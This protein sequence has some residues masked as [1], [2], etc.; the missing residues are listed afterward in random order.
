LQF[1]DRF[2]EIELMF[3][4]LG[5]LVVLCAPIN[6]ISVYCLIRIIIMILSQNRSVTTY[7]TRIKA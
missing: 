5:S 2:L 1:D 4:A 3:H 7:G 6:R